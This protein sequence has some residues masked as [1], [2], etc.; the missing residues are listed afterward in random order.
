MKKSILV[1]ICALTAI[2]LGNYAS[3]AT[4]TEIG[5]AGQ[6]PGDAQYTGPGG[7][8]L[9][10]IFGSIFSGTDADV[11][12]IN[13]TDPANFS[14]TT[15]N[16]TTSLDTA[17]FLFNMNGQAVYAN[18]DD[19]NGMSLGSTLPT[20][21]QFGPM[22]AGLYY[23]AI[24]LSGNE[25]VNFANQLM[26]TQEINSTD[27]R[28]P[29]SAVNGSWSDFD[30]NTSFPETGAYEIDFTGAQTAAV[31]E[32]TTTALLFIVI[33]AAAVVAVRRRRVA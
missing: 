8:P 29:N 18:D 6:T 2:C 28:G 14:A 13:I 15:V 9:S 5:D 12:V 19:P 17:L 7:Q 4:Y 23:I 1:L 20:G 21:S 31:P 33:G 32:P 26:F 25:P 27:V 30:G 3:A 11:F 24:S 16:G 22:A 10:A